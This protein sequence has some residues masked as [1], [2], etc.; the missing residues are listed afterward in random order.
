MDESPKFKIANTSTPVL[1]L[2]SNHHGSLSIARSLGRQGIKVFVHEPKVKVPVF[3][4]KYC[5][6]KFVWRDDK[7]SPRETVNYLLEVAEKIGERAILVPY[8]DE[9]VN[10]LAEYTNELK[11]HFIFSTHVT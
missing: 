2:G 1:V 3:Y 5:R 10:V 11:D 6:G 4:S 9:N 8:S 7:T